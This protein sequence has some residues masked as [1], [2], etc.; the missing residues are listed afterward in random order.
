[1]IDDVMLGK[2]LT[3]S[4][5]IEGET[6]DNLPFDSAHFAL[7]QPNMTP[8]RICKIHAMLGEE[9]A[10]QNRI[11]L[12]AFRQHWVRVGGWLAPSPK[13]VPSLMSQFC[14]DWHKMDSW[15]AHNRFEG[16]HPF[17]DGNGRV[18]RLLWLA[19]A[20]KEGY[21]F[22]RSFLHEYYYQTLRHQYL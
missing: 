3:E 7:R 2:F 17:E 14:A 13:D 19:K 12:G 5:L 16:I 20:R 22:S 8:V 11:R 15:E 9:M 6:W 18:G 4:N 1:M 10:M 21:D